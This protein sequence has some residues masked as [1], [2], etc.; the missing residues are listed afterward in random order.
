MLRWPRFEQSISRKEILSRGRSYYRNGQV[1]DIQALGSGKYR[2][3]IES[4]NDNVNYSVNIIILDNTVTRC[5]CNCPYT[6]SPI[7]KHIIAALF[8]IRH[9]FGNQLEVNENEEMENDDDENVDGDDDEENVDDSDDNNVIEYDD[10][11]EPI[12]FK[13]MMTLTETSVDGTEK[14]N[15]LFLSIFFY[16]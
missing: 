8:K 15:N 4:E 14:S 2:C 5:I 1:Q 10:D 16:E 6:Q 12:I 7:C 13:Q 11:D 9:D 3:V